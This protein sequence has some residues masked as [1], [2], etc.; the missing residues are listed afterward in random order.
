MATKKT[1]KEATATNTSANGK[2]KVRIHFFE[3]VL[4]TS[5]NNDQ[6]LSE[7]IGQNEDDPSKKKEEV[8]NMVDMENDE[9]LSELFEKA[10]T[11][12][13]RTKKGDPFFWD[14]QWKGFMKE[15]AS[16]LRKNDVGAKTESSGIKA[17]KKEIDGNIFIFPRRIV[18]H[19][20]D[21]IT[22]CQRPLRASGPQGERVALSASE[23]IAAR[24]TCD[25]TITYLIAAREAAIR[26]WLDYGEFH[27]TGQWRNS[28]A[29][30]FLWEELDDEGNQIGGNYNEEYYN[31]LLEEYEL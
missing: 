17:F 10:L 6:L 21:P 23:Q 9:E 24:A 7:H 5:P 29:G 25:F 16:F 14:Y 28:G 3:Y 26:E 1:A 8:E 30:R 11:V 22:I 31:E 20:D 19:T 27:G 18:I 2:M 13:P 4:A 15:K 12:F